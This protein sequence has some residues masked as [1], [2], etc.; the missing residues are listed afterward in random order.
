MPF[1]CGHMAALHKA[2]LPKQPDCCPIHIFKQMFRMRAIC[3]Q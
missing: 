2:P 3:D 1:W